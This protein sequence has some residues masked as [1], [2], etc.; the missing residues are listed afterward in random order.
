MIERF[1]D[2]DGKVFCLPKKA[3]RLIVY[4]FLASKFE[5]DRVYSEKEVNEILLNNHSFNDITLLRRELIVHQ[6]LTRTDDG[7]EYRK[8]NDVCSE[9]DILK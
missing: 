3:K 7:R 5:F 6:Y 1:L 8:L 4:D 2:K 9:N